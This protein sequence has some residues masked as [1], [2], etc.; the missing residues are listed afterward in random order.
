MSRQYRLA[1]AELLEHGKRG[2]HCAHRQRAVATAQTP[3]SCH[4]SASVP[5]S[6]AV[7]VGRVLQGKAQ[8]SHQAP[9]HVAVAEQR[10]TKMI[11]PSLV[12]APRLFALM[13][14]RCVPPRRLR[15]RPSPSS[16]TSNTQFIRQ[17]AQ[18]HRG[19]Q[20]RT[21]ANR[22]ELTGEGCPAALKPGARAIAAG[23]AQHHDGAAIEAQAGQA[24]CLKPLVGLPALGHQ[25]FDAP[26]EQAAKLIQQGEQIVAERG[27]HAAPVQHHLH[28]PRPFAPGEARQGLHAAPA[29]DAIDRAG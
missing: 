24:G 16:A 6:T 8:L 29:G 14:V 4:S 17:Q 13:A 19:Q 1:G 9:R 5:I 20:Q 21:N 25:H 3:P 11:Q 18:G 27:E 22:A 10:G 26:V 23:I 7:V 2:L 12:A 15:P 28:A